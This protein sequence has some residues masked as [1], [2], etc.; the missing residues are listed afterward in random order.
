MCT[1]YISSLYG[2]FLNELFG[3]SL[4]SLWTQVTKKLKYLNLKKRRNL[5]VGRLLQNNWT[6]FLG[7][8]MVTR[9]ILLKRHKILNMSVSVI[10][11]KMMTLLDVTP[12]VF[13]KLLMQL[14]FRWYYEQNMLYDKKLK[15]LNLKESQLL[16]W[17]PQS[18]L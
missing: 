5:H 13:S 1:I 7:S 15:I 14:T 9:I 17:F 11:P 10:V 3:N 12:S 6:N 4:L 2:T 8:L 16:F 18:I